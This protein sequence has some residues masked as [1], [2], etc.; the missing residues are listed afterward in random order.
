MVS[1]IQLFLW[2]LVT[3]LLLL[4]TPSQKLQAQVAGG[5]L[6]GTVQD[7]SNARISRASVVAR[8][9]ATGIVHQTETDADGLFTLP[10]LS[11][12]IYDVTVSSNGFRKAEISTIEVT[13]GTQKTLTFR[14]AVESSTQI[15][16]VAATAAA[17]ELENSSIQQ[18]VD[19]D[20]LQDLPLNGRDWTQLAALQPGVNTV[21]NQAS[22]GSNGS[23]DATKV[24]RGFGT[25]LSVSGTRSA[26]N[27]YRQDGISF[28]DYT[29]DA[30]GGVLGAQLGVDAIQEFSI[31]T[32]NYS[33][34]YG[35]TSGGVINS[36]TRSG[37]NRLHGSAYE[38]ARNAALDAR[39]YFDSAKKP[40]FSRN[41][42]GGTVG[43]P[44][45]RNK[46]FFFVNYEGLRQALTVTQL[47]SVPSDNARQGILSTGN[48]T[49][50]SN[51]TKA[52]QFYP[53]AN[54]G[55]SSSGDIGYYSVATKQSGVEDYVVTRL[56]HQFTDKDRVSGTFLFDRSDL[57]QPDQLNNIRF[58]HKLKRPFVSLEETHS[59]SPTFINSL[60]FGFNRNA[61]DLTADDVIN[62]LAADTTLGSV[63][64]RPAAKISV[65]GLATFSGGA[66]AFANFVFGWNSF[67]LYDDAFL[68]RG[69]HSL[70]FGF[71]LER[72]QSNNLFHFSEDGNF[73]F[74]TLTNFLTNQPK[75]FSATLPSTATT[76]G[77][78][79][80][81]LAGYVQ[82]DW[83]I[84]PRLTLNLGLRYEA[85]SV[86][87]EVNGH[88]GVLTSPTATTA[89][90]GNPYFSNPTLKN[91][92]PR[93][94]LA[95]DVFGN[96]KTAIRAGFGLYDVLPL[97]YQFLRLAS[98]GAPYN[99]TLA[100][101]SLPQGAFPTD[102]Y[103]LAYANYDP[104]TLA[105]QRVV[106]IDQ[107]PKRSYV[108]QW[109]LEV[110]QEFARNASFT[111]A[112]S[113]SRGVHLPY[114]TDDINIVMPTKVKGSYYWPTSGGT[115]LNPA[116]GQI[117][118]LQYIANSGYNGLQLGVRLNSVHGLRLQGSYTWQKSIDD[119]SS[120]LAGDQYLNSASSVPLWFD[121]KTR[122]G[123]S[124]FNLG[125][126]AVVSAVWKVPN[127]KNL[128]SGL[129][130][131][132]NNWEIGGIV[133]ASTGAPFSVFLGG[134]PL[135]MGSTDPWAYPDKVSSSACKSAVNPGNPNH[136]IKTQC[137]VFPSEKNRL[138]NS[139]RNTL[140]GPGYTTL[141]GSVYKNA[142]LERVNI[143]F[144]AELFNLLNH[145]NFAPPLDNY[146]VFNEDGSAISDAGKI[147]ST[148]GSSRQIQFGV[149]VQF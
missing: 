27:N 87:S 141:D 138:G 28:N 56:D 106:Y 132:T 2:L 109:H 78:R 136:Y 133:Q 54:A 92:E 117:D 146:Y 85:T 90:T 43:G 63:P 142:Q 33:A 16:E 71:A 29:N 118:A 97:P 100:A 19:Q 39:N 50:D 77:L 115:L 93:I 95:Y 137:F 12:S 64:G 9:R 131:F 31:L 148:Q 124:D 105:G 125:Q 86:P 114:A 5:G 129:R 26:Q 68:T 96:G 49:V 13:V 75:R 69:K 47:S 123:L 134:D 126:N 61:A 7:P 1:R 8:D 6:V 113:G 15:V 76:R 4:A 51:I 80:T 74:S 36:V 107:K 48:V 17:V 98:A 25:Q 91:F 66:G 24:T 58:H 67:Q 55:T 94:G 101:S 57:A 139:G 144:R 121:S 35:K 22:V 79:E 83:H 108:Q 82:D 127:A 119:G 112:Y 34:E 37:G 143:Q 52:L 46:S 42:F 103:T 32:S 30:P 88:I 102:A 40:P 111:V 147:T 53:T 81:L 128:S 21:R 18:R 73:S 116:V 104:S 41:Q 135:G 44:I 99:I 72:M 62:P 38:F 122:R 45:R 84:V 3:A 20:T 130:A 11:P 65:P 59:F 70:R 110:E 140:N 120:T 60:R 149:K 10:N 145:S 89:H 23:S 14:L